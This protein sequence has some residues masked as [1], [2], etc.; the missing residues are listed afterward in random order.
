MRLPVF[1]KVMAGY[2]AVV[3]LLAVLVLVFTF[4]IVKEYHINTLAANLNK[5]ALSLRPEITGFVARREIGS[6][7]AHVKDLGAAIETRITV[8]DTS[9]TVLADS[10]NDPRAME[11]HKARQEITAALAGETG[12]ALRFS[13]T[14]NEEMLYV[15]VP[16]RADTTVTAVLRVSLFAS[17]ITAL[18][19]GLQNRVVTAALI[20]IALSLGLAVIFSRNIS[21][22]IRRL[23]HASQRVADGDFN[24]NI[25]LKNRDEFKELADSYNHM[26]AQLRNLVGELHGEKQTLDTIINAIREAIVVLDKAGRVTLHNHAFREIA[27][28]EPI[29]GLH[30]WELVRS[31]GPGA[32]IEAVR[33]ERTAQ[34]GEFEISGRNYLASAALMSEH[35][36][37]VLTLHDVTEVMRLATIKKDLVVNVSHELRTP[38]TAIKGFVETL[39]DEAGD[40]ARHYLEIIRRHTDRL[41]NIVKDLQDLS[42]LESMERL[43]TE[44][45][46]LAGL[47]GPIVRMFERALA[48]KGLRIEMNVGGIKADADPY[49]L[50]QVFI[51]LIGNA[52]KYTE[53][54]KITITAD[55]DNS[56]TRI[57]IED[58]G[59]GIPREHIPRLFER[60]YVVDRS[61]SKTTGGTGLGLSIVKHIILAHRGTVN[62]ES[63]PGTGTTVII[64]LPRATR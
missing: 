22:P 35:G 9:G 15:A 13:R 42:A 36:E 63:A 58:T 12:R 1:L 26:V 29:N 5:I 3:I 48:D 45:I 4:R 17:D 57:T 16:L 27:A 40:E 6:L 59:I 34:T 24:V 44:N 38:L 52:I 18:L 37:I 54:G 2:L 51:N 46:D 49:R 50:E 25:I 39:E 14:V 31:A 33:R 21:K 55:Q 41:I 10:E 56:R 47:L 20:I 62:I 61:H 28:C 8:V 30:Y 53:K 11:N 32:L 7:D 23:V 43:E 64:T 19:R 60:F